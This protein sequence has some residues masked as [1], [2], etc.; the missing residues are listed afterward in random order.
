[1]ALNMNIYSTQTML[2]AVERA[3]PLNTFFRS[4]FFPEFD[5]FPTEEV[6]LDYK[7]GK[8]KMAPFVAPR[9]GG[10]TVDRDGYRTDKY[11]APKIAPQRPLT[12]DD[13]KI[14]GLGENVFSPRTPADRQAEILGRDLAEFEEMIVRR[15]EWM[16]RE[17]LFNGKINMKGFIDRSDSVF[18]DQ[19]LDYGFTNKEILAGGALWSA[20]TSKKYNDLKRWRQ[21][22]IQASGKAPTL[23]LYDQEAWDAFISDPDILDKLDV[24][25]AL[26]AQINPIIKNDALT[27][28][29]RLLELGLDL[30]CY[31]EWFLDDDGT[32]YP[33]VPVG[34]ILMARPKLGEMLYGAVTQLEGEQ[35][36]TYEGAR[37]PKSWA[38][39]NNDVRMLRLS[40]RPVPKPEDVDDWF[41]AKVL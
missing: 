23:V 32:E 19:K 36:L 39:Q 20:S 40:S 13:L 16:I 10:I 22:V 15:E 38:D 37:I 28:M 18:V 41:V 9:V 27:Y 29:G 12:V 25:N 4:T 35:F 34:H 8:R 1:M 11:T 7:K 2:A 6:L 31:N 21:R 14:R 5:T 17:L 24:R 3:M 30:Y 26:L 33:M